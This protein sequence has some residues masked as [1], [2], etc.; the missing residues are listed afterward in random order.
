MA[1]LEGAREVE[2]IV[3]ADAVGD[4]ADGEVGE[5]QQARGLEHHAVEDEVL[6]GAAGD[7]R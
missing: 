6:G 7:V 3:V 1:A 2:R 5:A 4:L